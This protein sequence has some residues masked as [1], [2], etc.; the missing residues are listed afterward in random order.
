[1]ASRQEQKQQTRQNIIQ[2]A[3]DKAS[4]ERGLASLSLR[5][6]AKA[7]G[8]AAPSFYRHFEDMEALGL[9][10]IKEAGEALL[11]IIADIRLARETS[12]DVVQ[13]SVDVCMAHFQEHGKLFRLLARE[14]T[15]TSPVM[16][17]ALHAQL[18]A[19]NQ[20]LA[21]AILQETR[22]TGRTL[23]DPLMVAEAISTVT[24]Y[25]GISSIDMPWAAQRETARRLAHHINV[26]LTGSET[27]ARARHVERQIILA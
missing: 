24:F 2:A 19:I 14:G 10:L 1:M 20:G 21:Q 4:E 3:L 11:R 17:Q 5:E 25:M 18:A 26:I 16:R 23:T 12:D 13:T 22:I 8:I 6:V 7:A 27:M 9:A 15:G